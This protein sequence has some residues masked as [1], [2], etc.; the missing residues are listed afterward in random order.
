[1][2]DIK[3]SQNLKVTPKTE[4]L[5]G[6]VCQSIKTLDL[7]LDQLNFLEPQRTAPHANF[8]NIDASLP[9][10]TLGEII[11]WTNSFA[12]EEGPELLR[13]QPA[14]GA[15]IKARARQLAAMLKPLSLRVSEIAESPSYRNNLPFLLTA[16][17]HPKVSWA[18]E[19]LYQKM[20]VLADR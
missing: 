10:V 11:Q 16:L 17:A 2:L 13:Q 6:E 18:F 15:L 9:D 20:Q 19:D 3:S 4:V 1:M 5:L 14:G 8:H 12:C 7:A